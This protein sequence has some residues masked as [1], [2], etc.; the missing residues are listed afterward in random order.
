MDRPKQSP[1]EGQA[2]EVLV[3]GK[4]KWLLNTWC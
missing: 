3:L 1:G 4:W 2:K